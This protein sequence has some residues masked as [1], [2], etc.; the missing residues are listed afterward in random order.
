MFAYE[1]PIVKEAN[2]GK[3]YSLWSTR[4]VYFKTIAEVD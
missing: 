4:N 2:D 3:L 1:Q